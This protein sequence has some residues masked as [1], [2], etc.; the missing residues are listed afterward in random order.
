MAPILGI[1]A[2]SKATTAADTGAMFPLQVITVGP[3][4]A[5]E[6]NFTNIPGTYTH[7]QIRGIAPGSNDSDVWIRFNSDTGSNY[8]AHRIYGDGSSVSAGANTTSTKIDT[9]ARTSGSSSIPA[10]AVIDILDYAN[11]NKYKTLR[12]L[13]GWDNNGSGYIMFSSGLW[14]NTSAITSIKLF[15]QVG[16]FQQYAQFALYAVKGA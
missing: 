5:S 3:A 4:G 15:P 8:A 10:P 11:T 16:S 13:F 7:L 6:V 9:A 1:W 14:M 12:S 2:S